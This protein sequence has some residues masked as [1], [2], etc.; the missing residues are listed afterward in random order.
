MPI[1]CLE[2]IDDVYE[3]RKSSW[4]KGGNDNLPGGN[5]CVKGDDFNCSY[6]FTCSYDNFNSRFKGDGDNGD[7]CVNAMD[8]ACELDPQFDDFID[9]FDDRF[10]IGDFGYDDDDFDLF[11]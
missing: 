9:D 7:G 3:S 5:D 6:D 1:A 10:G 8:E 11:P 4:P 2:S